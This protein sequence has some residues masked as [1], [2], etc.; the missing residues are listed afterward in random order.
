MS[1]LLPAATTL[2]TPKFTTSVTASLESSSRWPNAPPNDMLMTSTALFK[3]PL[4]VGSSAKSRPSNIAT[5]L[6]DVETELQTFTAYNCA[7]GAVPK[8]TLSKLC[9]PAAS[10]VSV[11]CPFKSIGLGS[12]ASGPLG[13]TSPVKSNPPITFVVG[14]NPAGGVVAAAAFAVL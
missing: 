14:N 10:A 7:P 4:L 5:P 1:P 9:P 11:P 13:H 3:V 6:Q 2:V 12:G 8:C